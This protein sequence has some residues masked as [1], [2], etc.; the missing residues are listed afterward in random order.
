MNIRK[1]KNKVNLVRG[2]ICYWKKKRKKKRDIWEESRKCE[3]LVEN[4]E[5]NGI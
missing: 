1:K 3:S 5:K 2:N 4:K